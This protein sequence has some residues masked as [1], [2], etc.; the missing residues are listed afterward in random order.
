MADPEPESEP[1]A[2]TPVSPAAAPGPVAA[3]APEAALASADVVNSQ[4][5]DTLVTVE[6]AEDGPPLTG[7]ALAQIKAQAVGLAL[8]NAVNAQQNAYVAAN[9]TVLAAVTRILALG[10]PALASEPGGAGG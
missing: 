2:A 9:A 5:V 3:P 10:E 4:V 6:A 7:A 8:L 1:S